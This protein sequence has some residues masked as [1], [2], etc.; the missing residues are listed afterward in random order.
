MILRRQGRRLDEARRP[1]YIYPTSF[2]LISTYEWSDLVK[3]GPGGVT[4]GRKLTSFYTSSPL[5][6]GI[7]F[8]FEV[9]HRL[10]IQGVR[11]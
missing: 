9:F 4:V 10:F 7:Y 5:S 3:G 6:T 8:E 2:E 11:N 1:R